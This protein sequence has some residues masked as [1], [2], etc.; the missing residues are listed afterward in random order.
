MKQNK[1]IKK[2]KDLKKGDKVW[3]WTLTDTTP[4]TVEKAKREGE[5]MRLTIKWDDSVYEC[6][7][8]ALGYTCIGYDRKFHAER[9]FTSWYELAFTN[10]EEKR[11]IRRLV[12]MLKELITQIKDI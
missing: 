4:I 8:H 7:G 3:Y 10:E 2:L 9:M 5:L 1:E 6:F 11:R 12:P